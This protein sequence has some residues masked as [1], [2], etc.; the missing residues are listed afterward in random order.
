MMFDLFGKDRV[1]VEL[2]EF[3]NYDFFP[4]F[5]GGIGITRIIS[6]MKRAGLME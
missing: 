3:L 2:D 1:E 4:R 5:G 6:A